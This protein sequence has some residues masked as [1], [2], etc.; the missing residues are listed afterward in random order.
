[1]KLR[2]YQVQL[3]QAI[4]SL[5]HKGIL[6]V[7]LCSPTGSGKTVTFADIAS[8]SVGRGSVVMIAVDRSELLDQARDKLIDYGLNP[9]VIT[10]GRTMRSGSNCYVAT[11][12]TLKKRVFPNIDLLIIDEAHKQTFDTVVKTYK[13]AGVYIIGATATPKRTGKMTQL[14]DVYDE[15][16]ET[17]TVTELIQDGFLVPAITYS[18]KLDTSKVAVKGN[19]YDDKAAFDMFNKKK[20][21]AD[22]VAKYNALTPN[23][24]AICFCQNV[25]HSIETMRAFSDA[26][27]SAAHVDGKT[28]KERRKDIFAAFKKG[29]IQVLCNADIATTG[30]DEWT[31]ETVIINRITMSLPLYMQMGGRGSRITPEKFQGVAGY[32]QKTHF[33]LLDMGGNVYAHGFWEQ[34]RSWS[35][36]HKR[37]EKLGIAPVKACPEDKFDQRGFQGCGCIIPAPAPKCGYCDYIFPKPEVENYL[38]GD[39]IQIENHYLLPED[40]VGRAWGDMS[41]EDLERVREA[42]GYKIGWIIAQIK[43]SNQLTLADYAVLKNYNRGWV[44]RMRSVHKITEEEE[45]LKR[46]N[47]EMH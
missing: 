12:Q 14:S 47:Y 16:V 20:M 44:D 36:T 8:E 32:L 13:A 11:V 27:I 33:N 42:K 3:K 1:M 9:S 21:Y 31:I 28:P 22:L 19:E 38:E 35:L 29:F 6:A 24:K 2:P 45:N 37:T 41:I 4:S 23:T 40:L 26:G 15:I 46:S 7:I 10:S 43:A 18:A 30:Y 17:V 39:F 34:E 25:E 5:F